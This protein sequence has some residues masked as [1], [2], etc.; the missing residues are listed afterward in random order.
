MAIDRD[1]ARNRV[2][3]ITEA[4]LAQGGLSAVNM[5]QVAKQAGISVGTI[6]N[7]FGDSDDLMRVVNSRLLDRLGGMGL[8]ELASIERQPG[9]GTVDKLLRLAKVYSDFVD[10]NRNAWAALLAFNRASSSRTT[11][12]WYVER[13][14]TLFGIIAGVLSDTP[15]GNDDVLRLTAARAI[16]SGVHG[17]VTNGYRGRDALASEENTWAQIDILVRMFIRGIER[18]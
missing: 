13:Q 3:E 2:I 16:W 10:G 8:A 9:L 15:L 18:T 12:G 5:R 14:E 6:Y 7:L 1:D 17:I 11:P 4:L